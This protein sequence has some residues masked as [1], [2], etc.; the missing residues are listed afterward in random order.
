MLGDA[1]KQAVGILDRR[2]LLNAFFP[3][4][5]FWTALLVVGFNDRGGVSAGVRLFANQ[6]VMV[7]ALLVSGYVAWVWFF[8]GVL[9]SQW[10]NIIRL[11]EGYWLLPKLRLYNFGRGWHQHKLRK[12][13]RDRDYKI[14]Y[15]RYPLPEHEKSVMPTTVGNILRSAELYSQDRYNARSV[16]LCCV[17]KS[18][19]PAKCATTSGRVSWYSAM[20]WPPAV[21]NEQHSP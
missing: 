15:L 19:R 3:S 5:V 20:R 9:A 1:V 13:K 7:Q 16:L 8:A 17:Q 2:F 12:L 21:R 10:R 4:L 14:I 6:D 18:R 11:Y